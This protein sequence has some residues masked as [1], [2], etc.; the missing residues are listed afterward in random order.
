MRH[1][2]HKIIR[3][4]KV[5][6]CVGIVFVA[7]SCLAFMMQ[8][9]YI[10]VNLTPSVAPGIYLKTPASNATHVT[11]CLA[12]EHKSFGF[13][14]HFCSP[15]NPENTRVLKAVEIRQNDKSLIVK[16]R[17]D[18]PIDSHILGPISKPQIVQFYRVLY[19]FASI[20]DKASF[21]HD[22]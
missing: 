21:L 1:H 5:R 14:G 16:G 22:Q 13:Y 3:I 17:G 20:H 12:P 18:R 11:F 19:P 9:E 10:V 8:F 2:W 15:D 6:A 4:G 7:T